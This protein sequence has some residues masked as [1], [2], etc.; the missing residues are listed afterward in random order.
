E[1]RILG[2]VETQKYA[3]DSTLTS[4]LASLDKI[5]EQLARDSREA[6]ERTSDTEPSSGSERH[7]N[8][9]VT[10]LRRHVTTTVRDGTRQIEALL[11][12]SSRFAD[13]K[14]PMPSTG[15]FAIDAQALGHL[16]TLVEER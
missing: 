7:L 8:G 3:H 11:Q 4:H 16:V 5:R 13:K 12:L 10:K 1:R 2:S 14:L 15:G 6:Q 9:V